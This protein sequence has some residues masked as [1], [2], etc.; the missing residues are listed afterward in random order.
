MSISNSEKNSI[1]NQRCQ[2]M[3]ANAVKNNEKIHK[4]VDSIEELG[5]SIPKNFFSCR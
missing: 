1:D 2:E 4:L 3:L 5:C